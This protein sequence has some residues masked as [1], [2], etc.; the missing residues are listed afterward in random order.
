ML[1]A[2][3]DGTARVWDMEIGDCVLVM[4]G[5]TGAVTS[6]ALAKGLLV[7]GSTDATVRVWSMQ[8]GHCSHTLSGHGGP[9]ER[10]GHHARRQS[11]CLRVLTWHWTHL[12]RRKGRSA[13]RAQWLGCWC[14]LCQAVCCIL[15]GSIA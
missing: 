12:E 5:H 6:F 15:G 4:K 9:C 8:T 2:S 14:A 10:R 13:E 1:A 11:D 7:T 3:R